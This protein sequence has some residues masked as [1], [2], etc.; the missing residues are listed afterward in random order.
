MTVLALLIAV[1][2]IIAKCKLVG[3]DATVILSK[4]ENNVFIPALVLSTFLK[5]FTVETFVTTWKLLLFSLIIVIVSVPIA[6][7]AAR[8]L[9]RDSYMRN[10]YTYGL[11]FSNFGFMGIPVVSALYPEYSMQYVLFVLPMWTVIYVWGVPCLLTERKNNNKFS[12]LKALINPMFIA[13]LIGA[14]VGLS[15]LPVP[16]FLNTAV[17]MCSN[18]MSP[19]AMILTGITFAFIDIKKVF[20]NVGIYIA[21]ALRLIVFPCLFGGIY[22]LLINYTPLVL[23]DYYFICLI[24]ATSMPLGLNSVVIPAAYGKD[25]SVAAGMALVSHLLSVATIPLMVK[26]FLSLV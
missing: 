5:S 21:S 11:I 13:L 20:C 12:S 16:A 2:Y 8:R 25:T 23:E 17:E 19:V 14:A 7:F 22:L 1:G 26:L 24:C 15:G 18:C 4:L 6:L 3:S 10:I 9:A